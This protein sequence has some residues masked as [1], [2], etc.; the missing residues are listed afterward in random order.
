MKSRLVLYMES[1]KLLNCTYRPKYNTKTPFHFLNN[2]TIDTY[3][4]VNSSPVYFK[5][6]CS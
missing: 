5:P 6:A 4:L 2:G 1:V 3:L